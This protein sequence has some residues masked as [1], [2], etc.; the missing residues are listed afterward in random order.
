MTH[1]LRSADNHPAGGLRRI[2]FNPSCARASNDTSDLLVTAG[3]P[4]PTEKVG[5]TARI[6]WLS[7]EVCMSLYLMIQ[8][9]IVLIIV[10]FY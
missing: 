1:M 4:P 6:A 5:T 2:A 9:F 8:S 10:L 7:G 3:E